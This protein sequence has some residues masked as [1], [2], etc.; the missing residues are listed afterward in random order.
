MSKSVDAECISQTDKISARISG[1]KFS[2]FKVWGFFRLLILVI[3]NEK[4]QIWE[5]K[6][7]MYNREYIGIIRVP[8]TVGSPVPYLMNT[9]AYNETN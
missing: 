7:Q 1:E 8:D 4:L 6:E 3:R 2:S 5:I 9:F